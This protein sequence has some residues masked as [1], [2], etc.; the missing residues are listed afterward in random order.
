M[1]TAGLTV[2]GARADV[3]PGLYSWSLP[4]ISA[5]PRAGQ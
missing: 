5:P 2:L 1:W 4:K 3:V